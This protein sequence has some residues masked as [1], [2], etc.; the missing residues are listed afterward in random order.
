MAPG[1]PGFAKEVVWTVDWHGDIGTCSSC[2]RNFYS[3]M[4]FLRQP[5]LWDGVFLTRHHLSSQLM[6][7][8]WHNILLRSMISVQCHVQTLMLL[9]W[10]KTDKICYCFLL[11]IEAFTQYS[12]L[13]YLFCFPSID[14]I[15][16]DTDS[17]LEDDVQSMKSNKK[18][19]KMSK[20]KKGGAS[21]LKEDGEI[22]DFMDPSS[23]QK[24]F[25]KLDE[26]LPCNCH[27]I[28]SD[29]FNSYI[30]YIQNV[31]TERNLWC[32]KQIIFSNQNL[33]FEDIDW[34]NIS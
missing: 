3:R 16:Q 31:F 33:L 22:I 9:S 28:I 12:S 30:S 7:L 4:A 1:I 20:K 26:K 11:S 34:N 29:I 27:L 24:V 32:D 10:S 18:V 5:T 23:T 8:I 14:E 19:N 17:E 25:C 21:Y 13:M 6:T 2:W 15:L